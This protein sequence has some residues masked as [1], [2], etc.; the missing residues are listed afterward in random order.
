MSSKTFECVCFCVYSNDHAPRHVHALIGETRVIIDL[1]AD[2]VRIAE[3]GRPFTPPNAPRSDLRKAIDVAA[4]HF[5][6]LV[7]LWE[8]MH[9]KV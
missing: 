9:G 2:G 7:Q 6:E 4:K 5:D 8:S 1:L 3:R